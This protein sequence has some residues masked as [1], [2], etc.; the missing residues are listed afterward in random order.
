MEVGWLGSCRAP[1]RVLV[2]CSAVDPVEVRPPKP[3]AAGRH[4]RE[5]NR[6]QRRPAPFPPAHPRGK[7]RTI[8]RYVGPHCLSTAIRRLDPR[9]E[10]R[11]QRIDLELVIDPRG[12]LRR[13]ED[14]EDIFLP[15]RVVPPRE[16]RHDAPVSPVEANPE[17]AAATPDANCR[18]QARRAAAHR[19]AQ[20]HGRKAN[21]PVGRSEPRHFY[22]RQTLCHPSR[23]P[24]AQP[25]TFPA[26]ASRTRCPGTRATAARARAPGAP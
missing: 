25:L 18:R 1:R 11:S 16:R 21:Q 15:E 17:R 6:Q 9:V 13:E 2:G 4:R 19:I 23:L 24:A 22:S 14:L 8:P 20:V 26:A 7:A 10:E 3:R 5:R 12:I